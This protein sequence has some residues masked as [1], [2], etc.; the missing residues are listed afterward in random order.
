MIN[1]CKAYLLQSLGQNKSWL[2]MDRV[3]IQQVI[4]GAKIGE[5]PSVQMPMKTVISLIVIVALGP[6]GFFPNCRAS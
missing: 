4:Y 2:G 5:G 3:K 6:M 1:K